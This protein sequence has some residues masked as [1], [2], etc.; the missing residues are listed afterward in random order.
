VK[1]IWL[2][3]LILL[4]ATCT[5]R[6]EDPLLQKQLE[7]VVGKLP[8]SP[9]YPT[10]R[11]AAR[12]YII[13]RQLALQDQHQL[14]IPHFR[15]AAVID[16]LSPAPWA[17]LAISLAATGRDDAAIVAWNEV[18]SRNPLHK[19]ALL[20]LGLDAARMGEVEK[21]RRLLAQHW[22]TQEAS[23]VE[24]V[25]RI[26]G[27]KSV[28]ESDQI[29]TNLLSEHVDSIIESTL[30]ELVPE[31][32]SPVWLGVMQQLVDLNAADIALRL[33]ATGS[34]QELH[35]KE[36]ATLLIVLPVLEAAAGGD[37]SITLKV[38]EEVALERT[39]S[40]APR[41]EE[42]VSLSEA[43]SIAAQSMSIV[44][45]NKNAPI[46]LYTAS[47]AIN[48]TNTL[49]LNNLAWIKLE[50]D[51]PTSEV[52]Q[53]CSQVLKLD[54]DSA[55]V[56][57][58]VGWMFVL[59]GEE[60]RSISLLTEAVKLSR[61]PSAETYDHLGDAYWLAG[62]KENAARAWETASMILNSADHRQ[63]ILEG[64]A[65]MAYKVWGVSVATPEALYD[66]ELGDVTRR[67]KEKLSAV[68]DGREPQLGFE[69]PNNGV[70]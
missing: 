30:M 32:S 24:A 51:G 68:Q 10:V 60:D 35:Q 20:I 39:V 25:L 28:F 11:R 47:L 59:L 5:V 8:E 3:S 15:R 18:I 54:P 43:L 27:L 65:S 2:S 61:E 4:F 64:Y 14:A 48:P 63:R 19:D 9:S 12:E 44:G 41:W 33:V 67:L 58:T 21:G 49:A 6:A 38:Y 45:K 29:I 55:Y 52:K 1:R 66:F 46:R 16:E 23:S 50:Q 36:L 17:S 57:D 69:V 53:L 22:L 13:G 7:A 70:K 40:L 37:G 34:I 31:A 42:P 62:Q 26:A 56:L